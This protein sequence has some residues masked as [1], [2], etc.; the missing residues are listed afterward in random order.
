MKILTAKLFTILI[1][2]S[3]RTYAIN[4]KLLFSLLSYRR[5]GILLID[6]KLF[7]KI[8]IL[9]AESKII[10]CFRLTSNL[11]GSF[12]YDIFE[13]S[14]KLKEISIFPVSSS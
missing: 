2:P 3:F 9:L 10:C 7:E 14:A 6:L 5:G 11:S 1:L 12:A 13:D 8:I 4:F